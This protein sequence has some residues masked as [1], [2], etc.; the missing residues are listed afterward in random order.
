MQQFHKLGRETNVGQPEADSVNIF[1]TNKIA[2]KSQKNNKHTI[3]QNLNKIQRLNYFV[4][5]GQRD[6]AMQARSF[7]SKI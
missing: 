6:K 7:L 2:N 5:K 4:C 1:V 3:K